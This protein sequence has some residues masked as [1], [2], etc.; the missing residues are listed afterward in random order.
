M[1]E[2]IDYILIDEVW[3]MVKDF[4][5]LFTLIKRA[6]SNIKFIIGDDFGQL[7]PAMQQLCDGNRVQ[8][9]KCRR[10]DEEL[11]NKCADVE[12]I[13]VSRFTPTEETYFN[14]AYTHRTR[15]SVNNKCMNRFVA[16]N[17]RPTIS[18]T[19]DKYNP[20]IQDVKLSV[21]MPI[22]AYTTNRKFKIL[23]FQTF[24]ITKLT[25]ESMTV[26]DGSDEPIT[27][28]TSD[29]HRFFY[30]GFCITIHASQ[31][32]TFA[33]KYTIHDWKFARF[34]KK[35]EYVALSRGTNINNIQIKV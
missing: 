28:K 31:G 4:Y 22:I 1:I 10:A 17:K 35:A 34:C 6:F 8:L 32:E 13:D 11:F 23:N 30:L 33:E 5:S 12:N 24:K 9:T 18:I 2:K 29:N 19:G 14:L 27:I 16:E 26:I 3:M 15:I 20:K 7:P 25:S 21:V